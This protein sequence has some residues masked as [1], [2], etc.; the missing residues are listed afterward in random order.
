ML[1][2]A[3]P[4]VLYCGGARDE[5]YTHNM[6]YKVTVERLLFSENVYGSLKST[7]EWSSM[8]GR[9]VFAW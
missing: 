6:V 1:E 4:L 2:V 5:Q 3:L 7:G 9:C 8:S